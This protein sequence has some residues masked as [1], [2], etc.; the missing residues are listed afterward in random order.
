MDYTQITPDEQSQMLQAIGAASIDELF[1][2]I[3]EAIRFNDLLD[4]PPAKSELELQR[5]LSEMAA[6]NL[7]PHN[8]PCFMGAGA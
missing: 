6:H 2:A 7:G 8:M 5:D 4:L 1:S 3:P